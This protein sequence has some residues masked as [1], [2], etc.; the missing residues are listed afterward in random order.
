MLIRELRQAFA[1]HKF[2]LTAAIGAAAETID[3]AYDVPAMYKYLDYVHVMCYD[4]HGKWEHKTG[5]NAPLYSRPGE[6]G[7]DKVLNVEYTIDYLNDLGANMEKTVLGVP[8][9]GRAFALQDPAKNKMGAPSREKSFQGPFTRED[10]FQGYN[11]I[12][13]EQ[14]TDLEF[15]WTTVWEEHHKAPYMYKGD[16]WV[17][18]DNE[19]SLRL[20]V[21]FA[22]KKGMAGVMTWSI[23]TDDFLGSCGGTKFPL[24]R[25]LNNALYK[26]EQGEFSGQGVNS[27]STLSL[28]AVSGSWILTKVLA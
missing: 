14:M 3:V 19:K 23:D 15:P 6:E 13:L 11:E 10:G 1:K 25:T 12:C 28:L 24:L 21:E 26:S 18:Y 22:Y 27:L 20:K 9:Y 4:Y 5:H 8:L 16:R 2:L 17:S 7:K